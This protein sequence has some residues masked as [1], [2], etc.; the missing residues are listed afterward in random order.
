[1][2]AKKN[3]VKKPAM[4]KRKPA[5]VP[6][7]TSRTPGKTTT[8]ESTS[9]PAPF[10][11]PE[12]FFNRELGWLHFNER[13]LAQAEDERLPLLE[14]VNFLVIFSSNLDE[15]FMKRV[16]L[17]KRRI[18]TGGS[19]RR[20]DGIAARPLMA[21]VRQLVQKLLDRQ[22]KVFRK[23]IVPALAAHGIHFCDFKD[24][25]GEEKKAVSEQFRSHV[26]PVLTPLAVDPGH[27]FPFISSLS[28]SLGVTL[29]N[30]ETEERLFARVKILS[31]LPQFISVK[32]KKGNGDR[33]LLS[34]IEMVSRHL[35]LLFPGM[36]IK[37]VVPFRLTRNA[38][39]E[40]DEEE[41]EDLMDLIEQEVRQRR[42]E[43]AVRLEH[44]PTTNQK[45]L[46]FLTEELELEEDDVYEMPDL[47][48][49]RTL[50]EIVALPFPDLRYPHWAP[51]TPKLLANDDLDLFTL[52]RKRDLLVH[53]PYESFTSSVERLVR[54][55][56]DDPN[57]L[58][59]KI[60][61]YRTDQNSPFIP[62]L[63][64][65]AEAG[66]Q[67]VAIVELKARFDEERNI[68]VAQMLEKVGVHVVY[69]LVG[70]KTH[71]KTTLVIRREG[72]GVRA[73]AHIGT[74]N[75]HA[76]TARLYTDLS[77]LTARP[78]ITDELVELFNFLT[79]RSLQR[80]Y[81][82]LLV[83]PL[84][85]RDRFLALIR[86]EA[87][88]ARARKP[89][90]II[91]K[92]NALED[93]AICLALIEAS[94]AGVP[95][96]LFVRGFCC[97]RPG[98]PSLTE[99]VRVFSV[100]GRFL[101]HSRIFHFAAGQENPRQG[102]FFIGSADWMTR[103]LSF[104]VELIAPVLD[105]AGRDLIWDFL[106]VLRNDHRQAWLMASDGT[107]TRRPPKMPQAS[108]VEDLGTHQVLM[109]RARVQALPDAPIEFSTPH[110]RGKHGKSDKDKQK[111]KEK[112][113]GKGK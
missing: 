74:G 49:Y 63:I 50:R 84:N 42:F 108:V 32:P 71:T 62:A 10:L 16:G 38:D 106:E 27:P 61:L 86:R 15:F 28:R 19:F 18:E 81:S 110:K 78:E 52:I 20:P 59:I 29:E 11:G 90:R 58:T 48:D 46:R 96:D 33:Y 100:V 73:Y 105:A 94:Q 75:Y 12:T 13:V 39:V 44:A 7:T 45:L 101:E 36:K 98:V 68:R 43:R 51:V 56:A 60:T 107:Y 79:G 72:N 103:N 109:M 91:A 35:D 70:F 57:V 64:R 83:A 6:N 112:D 34:L 82:Q 102:E 99:T 55:A 77:L 2:I 37:D 22:N 88:N 95:I 25:P 92:M 9:C 24:L 69:G 97:L 1:M 54:T 26:F 21:L 5:V 67:V 111:N 80:S 31:A 4:K 41:A 85:M 14:R 66:K 104:R 87:A 113:K 30:P 17:L 8:K 23:S 3:I 93:E 40:R 47:L 89:A 76:E 65:A 53:H